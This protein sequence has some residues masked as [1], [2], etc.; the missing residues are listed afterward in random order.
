MLLAMFNYLD[1]LQSN[2]GTKSNTSTDLSKAT[3]K[4]KTENLVN[5][6]A[7][8]TPSGNQTDPQEYQTILQAPDNEEEQREIAKKRI[9]LYVFC[10]RAIAYPFNAKQPTDLVRRQCKITP[11]QLDVI[12]E[13]FHSFLAGHSNIV[14]DEAFFNA[15]QSYYEVFMQSPRINRM[16]E[17][18]GATASDF[19]QVFKTNVQKRIRLLP[20]IDGMGKD[21]LIHSWLTKFDAIYFGE[22]ESAVD[23]KRKRAKETAQSELILTKEQLYDMFQYILGIQR[24]EHQQ[25][26]QGCQER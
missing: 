21:N 12:R 25:L 20:E 5:G 18:G 19:R 10:L 15:M 8:T 4:E 26:A 11:Q 7:S 16:V 3:G 2:T 24:Y 13:R 6:T 17:S 22:D 14:A 1:F 23:G 9:K